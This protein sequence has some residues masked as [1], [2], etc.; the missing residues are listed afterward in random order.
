MPVAFSLHYSFRDVHL[1][2]KKT[3]AWCTFKPYSKWGA[4]K[5]KLLPC[6]N[7]QPLAAEDAIS[8]I[9][10]LRTQQFKIS[11]KK[12]KKIFSSEK[13]AEEYKI[14]HDCQIA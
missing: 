1:M 11:L 9:E 12:N 2:K 10:C 4:L 13:T 5:A 3:E 8:F 14:V 6:K 7:L